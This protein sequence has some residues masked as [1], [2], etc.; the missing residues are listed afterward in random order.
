MHIRAASCDKG[1]ECVKIA[2]REDEPMKGRSL[3]EDVP[4]VE[5]LRVRRLRLYL[6]LQLLEDHEAYLGR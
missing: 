2:R 5:Y 3:D 6:G 1:I 4:L